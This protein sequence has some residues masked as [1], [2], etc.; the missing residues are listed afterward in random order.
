MIGA[1]HR[2]QGGGGNTV[3]EL[4]SGTVSRKPLQL[5]ALAIAIAFSLSTPLQKSF[6]QEP[7]EQKSSLEEIVVTGSRIQR[8][9]YVSATPVSTFDSAK[10]ESLGLI[11]VADVITQVP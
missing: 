10:M 6:A 4:N 11:N 8:S 7:S 2:Q 1:H 5:S 3:D 9:D